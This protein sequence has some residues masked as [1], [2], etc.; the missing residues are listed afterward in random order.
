M[1]ENNILLIGNDVPVPNT[2]KRGADTRTSGDRRPPREAPCAMLATIT[3]YVRA[4]REK[5]KRKHIILRIF[6]C[7]IRAAGPVA[8]SDCAAVP[9][10]CDAPC[11]GSVWLGTARTRTRT[12]VEELPVPAL[13]FGELVWHR[14][15]SKSIPNR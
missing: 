15:G 7:P 10:A 8:G 4:L 2:N 9:W 1:K 14:W 13:G 6:S 11:L 3:G 5:E 12:W